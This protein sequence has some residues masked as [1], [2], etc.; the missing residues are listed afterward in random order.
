MN[1]TQLFISETPPRSCAFTGHRTL[2]STFSKDELFERVLS[3]VKEGV[4]TFYNGMAM[5]FDLIAAETVLKIK[6]TY[7]N[8]KLIACIP[9][10]GQERYFSERDKVRYVE[11]L[12]RADEKKVLSEIYTPD[13]MLK[14]NRYMSDNADVLIAYLYEN[15][16]GTAYTV[17]YFTQKYPRKWVI[18][19]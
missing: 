4:D 9:C 15:R 19:I 16:G 5:G 1:E 3:L 14:R 2:L 8:V 11:I 6:E 7:K 12:K 18:Y 17:N 13:C 10:Y